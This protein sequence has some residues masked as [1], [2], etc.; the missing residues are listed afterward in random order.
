MATLYPPQP[1]TTND[2]RKK[3]WLRVIR[4]MY[5]LSLCERHPVMNYKLVSSTKVSFIREK[6]QKT[7]K[8]L[9]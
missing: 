8:N 4:N 7:Q 5:N 9:L 3:K 1:T 2:E 6:N